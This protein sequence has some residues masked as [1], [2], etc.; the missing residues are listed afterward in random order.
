VGRLLNE[1]P[2]SPPIAAE[3]RKTKGQKLNRHNPPTKDAAEAH[4]KAE[5]EL[6]LKKNRQQKKLQGHQ[7]RAA[8]KRRQQKLL[9]KQHGTADMEASGKATPNLHQDTDGN[10]SLYLVFVGV[11]F[12]S[13]LDCF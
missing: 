4:K 1:V 6:K 10:K 12:L 5:L 13:I 2:L 7:N 9:T 11:V 3:S 8:R